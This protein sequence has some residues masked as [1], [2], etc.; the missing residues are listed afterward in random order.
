MNNRAIVGT[1]LLLGCTE[2]TFS[3]LTKIDVFQ[4]QRKN[5]VDVLLVVDNSCSMIDEQ[6]KLAANFDSFIQYFEG[7]DVDWQLGV[8][9]TDIEQEQFQGRLV[10]GDDEI[11]LVDETG[12]EVDR[13]AYTHDWSVE[14]GV[15][16]SL[17]PTWYSTVYND[18]F[19]HWCLADAGT[20]GQVNAGCGGD[21]GEGPDPTLGMVVITEFMADPSGQTDTSAVADELGEWVEISNIGT[22]AILL[23]GWFLLD[24][25]RNSFAIPDGTT[26]VAGGSLVFGRSAD[27]TVNGGVN[28]DVELGADFGLNDDVLL[29]NPYVQGPEE[30]FGEMVA[31]GTT[32]SGLEMGLEATRRAI[33]DPEL[34]F[35]PADKD[36]PC[37]PADGEICDDYCADDDSTFACKD[38]GGECMDVPERVQGTCHFEGG[39]NYGLVREGANLT[40]LVVSDEE[41]SSP[42]PVNDYLS[43]FAMVKGEAAFRDHSIMNVSAVVGDSPPEFEG[44]PSCS[45][46]DGYADYGS[47]YVYA[48]SQTSGLVDSICDDDF[49]PIVSQLGLTLSGLLAEFALS[50]YPDLDSLAVGLYETNDESTK[51]RDLTLDVDYTYV[52]ERNSIRFEF[53]QVPESEQYIQAEYKV[54]SGQ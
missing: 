47:R 43:D 6:K 18:S 31:Q 46:A 7:T 50:A 17:D 4:Q 9:T 45:S 38:A 39:L 3:Q 22:E 20:P 51:I 42:D 16:Y 15:A 34:T 29:L 10:G 30:I 28:V 2:N 5:T 35:A 44:E 48:V 53:A 8:I 24:D 23:D 27:A 13:V 1:L 25:G 37:S 32:G 41:D 21:V 36:R 19:A 49:S 33:T 12:T 26:I 14:G 40:I 54:R 52:E 11:V